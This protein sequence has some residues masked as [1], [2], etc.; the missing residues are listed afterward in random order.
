MH[1]LSHRKRH[2]PKTKRAYAWIVKSTALVNDYYFYC[3]DENFGP[4]FLKFCSYFLYTPAGLR[5][6][7]T[8]MPVN[9]IWRSPR[10]W[11]SR[12][13]RPRNGASAFCTTGW[14]DWRLTRR[15]RGAHPG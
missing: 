3:V 4:F 6:S 14:R 1:R 9:R 11:G 7:P 5:P 15:V 12:T 8:S 13:R 2:N 10:N